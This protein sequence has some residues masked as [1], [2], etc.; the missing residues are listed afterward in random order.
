MTP[1]RPLP[2]AGLLAPACLLAPVCLLAGAAG[3][4]AAGPPPGFPPVRPNAGVLGPSRFG[5]A[6]A[7]PPAAAPFWGPAAPPHPVA[8]DAAALHRRR[9][10]NQFRGPP[11]DPRGFRPRVRAGVVGRYGGRI[12]LPPPVPVRIVP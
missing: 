8:A 3:L 4:A 9:F 7:P 2:F 5:P 12:E 1:A 11:G 6:F 10:L